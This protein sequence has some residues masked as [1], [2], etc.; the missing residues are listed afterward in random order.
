MNQPYPAPGEIDN[1]RS[2]QLSGWARIGAWI[3]GLGLIRLFGVVLA[4]AHRIAAVAVQC[5]SRED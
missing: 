2:A 3:F 5:E 4:I 1:V